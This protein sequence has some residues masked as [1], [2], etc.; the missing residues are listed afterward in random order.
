VGRLLVDGRDILIDADLRFRQQPLHVS[1]PG[2]AALAAALGVPVVPELPGVD[3]EVLVY[4]DVWDRL[5]TPA[6]EP[7]LNFPG[8]G[9]E[10]CAR[11]KREWV[12]RARPGINVP[13]LASPPD[14]DYLPGHSYCELARI[15]RRSSNPSV[16]A[17]DVTDSRARRI[18]VPP[19]TLVE[20][21][22]GLNPDEYRRGLGRP[23]LSI[24]ETV[25]ALVH[26]QI[27]SSPDRPVTLDVNYD[28]KWRGFAFNWHTNE[29]VASWQ[30]NRA[31]GLFQVFISRLSLNNI[32]AGFEPAVQ[33]TSGAHQQG[34]PSLAVLPDGELLVAYNSESGNGD[35]FYKRGKYADLAAATPQPV[36]TSAPEESITDVL[37]SM[38]HV[39]FLFFSTSTNQWYFRRLQYTSNTWVDNAPVLLSSTRGYGEAHAAVD[40]G[41]KIW[42]IFRR[43]SETTTPLV[44]EIRQLTLVPGTG[45]V[46]PETVLATGG[47]LGNPVVVPGYSGQAWAFWEN[48]DSGLVMARFAS[49]AWRPPQAVPGTTPGDAY[50]SVAMEPAPHGGLWMFFQRAG[51]VFYARYDPASDT[52]GAIRQATFSAGATAMHS[53][54]PLALT[55]PDQATW[56]I[57][58]SIRDGNENLYYKRFFTTI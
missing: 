31:G 36:A 38:G 51:Q 8:L 3:G 16:L 26:G 19:A 44:N 39:V 5:L 45:T 4:V 43:Y 56:L 22:L 52:W 30:S 18:L 2:S 23:A 47:A 57:F 9:T 17:S 20:D 34:V 29:L 33:I 10:S 49:G 7:S 13:R 25:N 15:F 32:D 41:G 12:V 6:E 35:V 11:L 50:P 27:P 24:R 48:H 46:S 53:P 28:F 1:Q 42:A 14:P 40:S 37:L 21:V 54:T 58:Q 55:G